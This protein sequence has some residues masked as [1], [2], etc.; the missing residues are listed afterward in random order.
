MFD[1]WTGVLMSWHF[2]PAAL[3]TTERK[4]EKC[5]L[6]SDLNGTS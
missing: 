4:E 2:C 6:L 1:A 3:S 5:T